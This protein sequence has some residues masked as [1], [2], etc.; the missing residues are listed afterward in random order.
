MAAQYLG[1]VRGC[2]VRR[3]V[4]QYVVPDIDRGETVVRFVFGMARVLPRGNVFSA[5]GSE[6]RA[7]SRQKSTLLVAA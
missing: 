5:F 1:T 4:V 7:L 3:I 6:N 2:T